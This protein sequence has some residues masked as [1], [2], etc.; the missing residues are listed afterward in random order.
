[1][2]FVSRTVWTGD[3]SAEPLDLDPLPATSKQAYTTFD[4]A[5]W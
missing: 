4:V 3:L 2:N 1:M 5:V